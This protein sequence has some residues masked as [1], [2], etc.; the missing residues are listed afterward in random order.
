ME[1]KKKAQPRPPEEAIASMCRRQAASV[2]LF[3][4]GA[5]QA[6]VGLA[7]QN[8][9]PLIFA[10][11]LFYAAVRQRQAISR[12]RAE[13]SQM[14][15]EAKRSPAAQRGALLSVA[16]LLG[17]GM[18]ILHAAL[19]SGSVIGLLGAGA[20]LWLGG[21]GLWKLRL[22]EPGPWEPGSWKPGGRSTAAA[23][24]RGA[25]ELAGAVMGRHNDLEK[26]TGKSRIGARLKVFGLLAAAGLFLGV[27]FASHSAV[28]IAVG[29][30][31]A[32][33]G[34]KESKRLDGAK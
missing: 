7:V 6:A 25:E 19:R 22:W 23:H 34:I 33:Y 9:I 31:L 14:L 28:E 20:L 10:S 12:M 27:G 30:F 8:Y 32:Y 11:C 16:L 21:R 1:E 4:L 15:Q 13:N 18:I 24:S 29:A 26:C 2:L 5:I 3:V 17:F